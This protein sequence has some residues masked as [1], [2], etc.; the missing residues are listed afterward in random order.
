MNSEYII[1]RQIE[2]AGNTVSLRDGDWRS[3]PF[4]ALISPLWRKK[5][6]AFENSFTELGENL[7]EYYLYIGSASHAVTE[8]SDDALLYSNGQVYEFKHRDCVR[9]NDTVLYY[10]GILRRLKGVGADED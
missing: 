7:H 10:T 6:S 5:S 3:V 1:R 2:R 8:L 9:V 4:K